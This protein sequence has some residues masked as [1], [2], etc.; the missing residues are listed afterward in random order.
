MANCPCQN[1]ASTCIDATAPLTRNLAG[2]CVEI[3]LDFEDGNTVA[4]GQTASGALTAEATVSPDA[5]NLLQ[6]LENGLY[7]ATDPVP[8]ADEFYCGKCTSSAIGLSND[9]DHLNDACNGLRL[10]TCRDSSCS[11]SKEDRLWAPPGIEHSRYQ[12]VNGQLRFA[13]FAE[14]T[15]PANTPVS[16][17]TD[18]ETI[19]YVMQ[20]A[21]D[22]DGVIYDTNFRYRVTNTFCSPAVYD[23][24]YYIDTMV[25]DFGD[26]NDSWDLEIF[27]RHQYQGPDG[28]INWQI[29]G[30]Q[31]ITAPQKSNPNWVNVAGYTFR[32]QMFWINPNDSWYFKMDYVCR[33]IATGT[34]DIGINNRPFIRVSGRL[35]TVHHHAGSVSFQADTSIV[36]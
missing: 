36:V 5:N 13:P 18:Y 23:V 15:I 21:P 11:G 19:G 4:F 7:V 26:V 25:L 27:F 2:G 33:V 16:N 35:D 20:T 30:D 28:N 10:R 17:G 31:R 12:F 8:T 34:S 1:E 9:L 24:S 6:A 32:P 14:N 3:G 22:Y 29:G